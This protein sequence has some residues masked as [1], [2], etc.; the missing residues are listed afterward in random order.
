M[1]RIQ[2]SSTDKLIISDQYI[3]K[4]F[5]FAFGQQLLRFIWTIQRKIALEMYT[6]R[7][8]QSPN[9][10]EEYAIDKES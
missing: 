3:P 6:M 5:N 8:S 10:N 2:T 7:P 9:M 4:S 1:Y